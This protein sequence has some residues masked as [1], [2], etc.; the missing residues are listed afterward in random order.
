M[1]LIVKGL[2]LFLTI[3]KNGKYC[4]ENFDYHCLS[5]IIMEPIEPVS[6]TLK[7]SVE[8]I[9]E[10]VRQVRND[11]IQDFL[12]DP[13]LKQYFKEQF[14]KELNAIKIEFV[15]RELKELLQSPV[16]L[17]HYA[18]LINEMRETNTASLAK[19]NQEFFYKELENIFKRYS[20]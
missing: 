13:N 14:N 19:G 20:Y 2:K 8:K 9:I 16:D 10:L 6:G 12:V 18:S 5:F 11:L 4:Y 17:T 1:P 3:V 7:I 15:K